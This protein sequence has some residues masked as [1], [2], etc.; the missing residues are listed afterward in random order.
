MVLSSKRYITT[1]LVS[2]FATLTLLNSPADAAN[3]VV[4]FE[5]SAQW[6]SAES[7]LPNTPKD[8]YVIDDIYI[9]LLDN[10]APGTVENFLNYVDDNDYAG[11]FFH[12]LAPGF[13]LQ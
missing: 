1:L 2:L 4:K 6:F 3:T 10:A 13:V 7:G 8:D 5:I 9:R 11:S 12:R